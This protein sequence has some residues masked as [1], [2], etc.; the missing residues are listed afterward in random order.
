MLTVLEGNNFLVADDNGDVGSGSEGLYYNDTR[1][2]SSWRLLLNGEP[3]QLLSSDTVDYYSAAVFMQNPATAGDAGRRRLADPRRVRGRR[4]HAEQPARREPPAGTGRAGAAARVRLRLPRP[5]RG[6][7]ARVPRGGP[8][9]H[10]PYP[11]QLP[12]REQPR[13]RRE[14]LGVHAAKRRL[15]CAG[16]GVGVQARRGREHSITHQV[17]LDPGAIWETR[18]NVVL[19]SG[20]NERRQ[21]YTS[22]YFG[23]ERVRVEESM[24]AWR[25][26]AP[27]L[28]TD[29]EDLRN[30]Y[31]R[32]L[33]DLAALRM[34]PRQ[35]HAQLRDLPAAGLPWFMTVFGRDTLIT[36]YQTML[37]GPSWRPARWRR[38]PPC[39]RPSGSTSA[40]PSRARS[41]TRCGSAG[42]RSR[43]A[44][45]PT[46]A[47]STPPCCS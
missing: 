23:Q 7:G 33:A 28:A 19:L 37:L 39:R 16:A 20:D 18:A 43:A 21:R 9:L 44:P 38:W 10:R 25:L 32:S 13:R 8:G 34:R 15:P 4:R 24:R 35:G 45:S 47:A 12:G 2:L 46:T 41:C 30:T 1:Y 31:H 36:S 22:F 6:E 11:A 3:P 14:L 5:V 27:E 40:T 29:W 17:R 42:W 26:H